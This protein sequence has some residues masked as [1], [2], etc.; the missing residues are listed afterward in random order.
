MN[1]LAFLCV[2]SF[3]AGMP[4]RVAVGQPARD[5]LLVYGEGFALGVKEPRGWRG[6][7]E[8]AGKWGANIVFYRATETLDNASTVIRILVGEKTDENT[9]ADLA[10]DMKGYRERFPKVQFID[11][12][13]SHPSYPV[14]GKLFSVAGSFYEYV[15]YLNPGKGKPFLLSASMNKSVRPATEEQLA[16]F[17]DIVASLVMLSGKPHSQ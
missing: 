1:L 6:D 16:A 12:D 8:G 13:V 14:F 7:T 17:R 5:R 10:Y 2:A 3:V 15:V 9:A 11:L 4:P